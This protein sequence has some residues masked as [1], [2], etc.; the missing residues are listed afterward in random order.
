VMGGAERFVTGVDQAAV[1]L[2]CR[3]V[4]QD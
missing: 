1:N 2:D 4:G 3:C